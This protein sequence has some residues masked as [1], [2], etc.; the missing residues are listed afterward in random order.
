MSS[1]K[2]FNSTAD[3]LQTK[4]QPWTHF[5]NSSLCL[6]RKYVPHSTFQPGSR[7]GKERFK[8]SKPAHKQD[9]TNI[10]NVPRAER[11]NSFIMGCQVLKRNTAFHCG[12]LKTKYKKIKTGLN[13]QRM[14]LRFAVVKKINCALGNSPFV[15]LFSK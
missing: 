10:Y 11:S 15:F 3:S 5:A 12:S 7:R 8:K 6:S 14:L 4:L 2:R 1:G 9:D 13:L